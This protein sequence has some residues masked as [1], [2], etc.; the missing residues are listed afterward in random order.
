MTATADSTEAAPASVAGE[1][2]DAGTPL[3]RRLTQ[4]GRDLR[5]SYL[6]L[7]GIA[8]YERYVAHHQAHHPQQPLLS[9]QQFHARAIDR[10]YSSRGARCC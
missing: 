10:K 1:A 9:P 4:L 5:R 3:V 6:Q 2:P 7:F 8:D